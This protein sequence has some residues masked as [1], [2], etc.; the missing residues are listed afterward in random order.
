MEPRFQTKAIYLANQLQSIHKLRRTKT[1]VRGSSHLCSSKIDPQ[2][3]Q[4]M[5][6]DSISYAPGFLSFSYSEVSPSLAQQESN[7]DIYLLETKSSALLHAPNDGAAAKPR[8]PEVI[9]QNEPRPH[10]RLWAWSGALHLDSKTRHVR[11]KTQYSKEGRPG[12]L[13]R[14][15]KQ[16]ETI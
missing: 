9:D 2:N 5:V 12:E 13:A 6:V 4:K 10:T 14:N 16:V 1:T 3:R 8:P 15:R 7:T 11:T